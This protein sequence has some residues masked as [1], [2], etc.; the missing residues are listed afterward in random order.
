V[1]AMA[2]ALAGSLYGIEGIP[3]TLKTPLENAAGIRAV[4]LRLLGQ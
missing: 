1:A 4:E 2:G 3:E